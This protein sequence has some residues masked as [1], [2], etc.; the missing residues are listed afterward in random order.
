MN[1]FEKARLLGLRAT[2]I[3]KGALSTI[4]VPL[5]VTDALAIARLEWEAGLLPFEVC[6]QTI[7]ATPTPA[8]PAPRTF[9]AQPLRNT[10]KVVQP[11]ASK[12]TPKPT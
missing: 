4:D 5:H 12:H 7:E 8:P 9:N 10:K 3:D 6:P 1:R 2:A 11:M